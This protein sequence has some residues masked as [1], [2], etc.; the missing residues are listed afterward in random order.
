MKICVVLLFALYILIGSLWRT[1][2]KREGRNQIGKEPIAALRH[3]NPST[4][5]EGYSARVKKGGLRGPLPRPR[6]R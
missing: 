4:R 5:L 2:L 3:D 1:R 6:S